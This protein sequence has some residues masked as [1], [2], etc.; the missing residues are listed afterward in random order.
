MLV[1][2]LIS[3]KLDH[4]CNSLIYG[5]PQSLIDHLKAVQNC[6]ARLVTLFRKHDHITPI[7]QQLR[8]L[9]VYRHIKYKMLLLTFKAA[10]YM[11]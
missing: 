1:H 7:L 2:T 4:G 11:G 10:S 5:H 8:W 6:A 3:S 9:P